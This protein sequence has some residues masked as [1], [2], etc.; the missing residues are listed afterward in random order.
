MNKVDALIIGGGPAGISASIWCKR[1]NMNHI[2]IEQEK[3]LG[4]Q[5]EQIQN[6]IIDYPG[7][8]DGSGKEIKNRFI[9]HM[10]KLSCTYVTNTKV[11]VIDAINQKVVV[12]NQNGM[13][14]EITYKYLIVAT[15]ASNR[16]LGVNGEREMY[17]RGEVFS[18]SKDAEQFKDKTVV[19]VGGGDRAFEGAILL[20]NKGAN[21]TLVHR[22]KQ[23]RARNEYIE[24]VMNHP[25]ISLLLDSEVTEIYGDGKV[26]KIR[27]RTKNGEVK[28]I[29][30][31]AVLIRLGI[32]PNSEL[33]QEFLEVDEKGYIVTDSFGKTSIETIYAIGDVCTQ[34]EYTSI[35][36]SVGQGM[37]VAKHLSL[38]LHSME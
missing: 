33:A 1:L 19:V 17:Q 5:L 28:D 35:S 11:Q 16:M 36:S 2:L 34:P 27:V 37:K 3:E 13:T 10:D 7:I 12:S 15:G 31:N 18:A 9:S 20:A 24:P 4:G 26:E 29:S 23:F 21:V 32:K 30:T 25:N 38:L 22:S 8:I 6:R 14:N